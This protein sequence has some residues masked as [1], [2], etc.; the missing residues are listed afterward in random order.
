MYKIV[1]SMS[2]IILGL[3]E[4]KANWTKFSK[5]IKIIRRS[6]FKHCYDKKDEVEYNKGDLYCL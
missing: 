3:K 1:R 4:V 2:K 5:E 6:V